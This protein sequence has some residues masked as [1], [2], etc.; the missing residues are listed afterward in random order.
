MV[1]LL[2]IYIIKI[3]I[4]HHYANAKLKKYNQI[5][6]KKIIPLI[7]KKKKKKQYLI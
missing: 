5:S 1:V 7:Y 3:E 6:K 4:L 2:L